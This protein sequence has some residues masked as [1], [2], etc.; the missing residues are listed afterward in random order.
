[1]TL[2][3]FTS[4]PLTTDVDALAVI[5]SSEFEEVCAYISD[6]EDSNVV[7]LLNGLWMSRH[8][9]TEQQML[10][11]AVCAVFPRNGYMR[12]AA[13]VTAI[14][15][16]KACGSES[17]LQRIVQN[18]WS[19][20]D[21]RGCNE[22]ILGI[23][24]YDEPAAWLAL[25]PVLFELNKNSD[26]RTGLIRAANNIALAKNLPEARQVLD[27]LLGRMPVS[28]K[29]YSNPNHL[30]FIESLKLARR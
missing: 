28:E 30:K 6:G 1:M 2:S 18:R 15:L 13:S 29:E 8:A 9:F 17:E 23:S 3:E 16:A 27:T 20:I 10:E 24:G 5:K 19:S 25:L 14:K 22:V 7:K 12:C 26:V 21:E 4:K 11:A